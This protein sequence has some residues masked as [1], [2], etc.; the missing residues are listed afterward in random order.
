MPNMS[1]KS[2]MELLG[3]P[4]LPRTGRDRLVAAAVELFYRHGFNAVGVDRIIAAAGVT[5]TTF[6]KHFDS[7][8]ELMVAA[9]RK[10]DAWETESWTRAVRDIAGP[11]DARAQL[12]ALFEVMDRWFN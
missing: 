7:K 9:V 2:A 12:L 5:K 10:R 4:A 1:L 11:D 8:D 3:Q 6:Y